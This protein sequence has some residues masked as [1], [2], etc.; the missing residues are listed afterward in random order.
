MPNQICH[1]LEQWSVPFSLAHPGLG[2]RRIAGRRLAGRS[3]EAPL[4]AVEGLRAVG[5]DPFR[6]CST[7]T[8]PGSSPERW[9]LAYPEVGWNSGCGGGP[10]SHQAA[11]TEVSQRRWYH[12]GASFW[13][14][15]E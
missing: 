5:A 10:G 9:R 13:G 2:A 7:N 6:G 14:S 8:G 12:F 1:H 11:P 3:G 4:H 15:A